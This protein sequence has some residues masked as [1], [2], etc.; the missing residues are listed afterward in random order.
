[1]LIFFKQIKLKN[2]RDFKKNCGGI[3]IYFLEAQ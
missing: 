1:M 3:V 2:E